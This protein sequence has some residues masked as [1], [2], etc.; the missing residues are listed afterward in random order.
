[1]TLYN[2]LLPKINFNC[3]LF[4]SEMYRL[5]VIAPGLWAMIDNVLPSRVMY[6]NEKVFN[7]HNHRNPYTKEGEGWRGKR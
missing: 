7:R 4:T 2:K 6:L 1:M 5:I 3:G